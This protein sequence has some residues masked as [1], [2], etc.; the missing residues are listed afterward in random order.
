M[1][2]RKLLLPLLSP[3]AVFGSATLGTVAHQ[4]PLSTGFSR[5]VYWSRLPVPPPGDLP[6][7]GIRPVVSCVS[8]SAGGFFTTEPLGKPSQ[9]EYV[10]KISHY[11]NWGVFPTI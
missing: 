10:P 5:Q 3:S 6:D 9:K 4:G 11:S 7:P 1:H 8:C 2:L